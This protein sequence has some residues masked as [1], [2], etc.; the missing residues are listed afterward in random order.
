MMKRISTELAAV[1]FGEVLW[2]VLPGARTPGGAPMNVAYHLNAWGVPATMISAVGNDRD[3]DDLLSFLKAKGLDTAYIQRINDFETGQA[4]AREGKDGEMSYDIIEPAAWDRIKWTD[5][6]RERITASDVLVFG[7][8][9]LRNEKSRD[10]LEALLDNARF[11]A[12]DVNL[13]APFYREDLIENLLQRTDLLKVNEYELPLLAGW[14]GVEST[15]TQKNIDT[16]FQ[17]FP[18]KEIVLTR[19]AEGADYF[20]RSVHYAQKSFTVD[21]IDTVGSGDSFLAAFL[22]QR[23]NG[24]SPQDALRYAAAM[25]AFVASKKGACPEYTIQDFDAFL[26]RSSE[27]K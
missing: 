11:K 16:L 9:G 23:L 12:F 26:D 19:G 17:G 21:V 4:I 24:N 27:Q 14:F 25:G 18:L 3:G 13:R 2:D 7:S 15:V 10:T 1:C 20:S 6:L 22:A 5:K 8:L